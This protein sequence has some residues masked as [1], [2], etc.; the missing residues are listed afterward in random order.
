M[1]PPE[2]AKFWEWVLVVLLAL[3]VM[4]VSAASVA[5]TV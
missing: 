1:T 3:V 4:G 2:E 5:A